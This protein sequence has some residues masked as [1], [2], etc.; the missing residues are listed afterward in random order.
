[1]C[2]PCSDFLPSF[3]LDKSVHIMMIIILKETFPYCKT[4]QWKESCKLSKARANKQLT[5]LKWADRTSRLIVPLKNSIAFDIF[6]VI[7]KFLCIHRS[8]RSLVSSVEN[9]VLCFNLSFQLWLTLTGSWRI[10]PHTPFA[11][12]NY[13][14]FLNFFFKYFSIINCRPWI[15][16]WLLITFHP[17]TGEDPSSKRPPGSRAYFF[18]WN[19]YCTAKANSSLEYLSNCIFCL[20]QRNRST[21]INKIDHMNIG[22]LREWHKEQV[23]K[24]PF[25]QQ[26]E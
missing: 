7:N 24:K 21:W 19:L 12:F 25:S 4:I 14:I 8:E 1:M 18:S 10:G 3:Y 20:V 17:V 22:I 16:N 13:S 26:E 6:M 2:F 15:F 23:F 11:I 9:I 5:C